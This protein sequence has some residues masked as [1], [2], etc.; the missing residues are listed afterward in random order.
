MSSPRW[1]NCRRARASFSPSMDGRSPSSMS[2]GAFYGLLNRCPHQGGS[3]CDGTI[4]GLGPSAEA[5]PGEYRIERRGEIIRCPWHGWEFDIRTGQSW[6]FAEQDRDPAISG[7]GRARRGSGQGPLHRRDSVRVG[8]GR[9]RRRRSLN[10]RA[11]RRGFILRDAR[12]SA[13]LRMRSDRCRTLMVRSRAFG[14]AFSTT[15]PGHDLTI[16]AIY[17]PCVPSSAAPAHS[18]PARRSD[19]CRAR[20]CRRAW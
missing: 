20:I 11:A 17:S 2:C 8:R 5:S 3:L 14:A 6:V 16:R 4:T 15:R 1:R 12:K 19:R 13:L 7:R 18:A 10:R 9:L